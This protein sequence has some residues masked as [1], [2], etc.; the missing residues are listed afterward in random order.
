MTKRTKMLRKQ[1]SKKV[2]EAREASW[3]PESIDTENRT[4]DVVW[5]TGADVARTDFWTGNR[6]IE[7]LKVDEDAIDL[8]RLTSGAALLD[9][10][11]RRSVRNQIGVV[12]SARI[13]D[14]EG[15]ATVRFSERADDIFQDVADG[16]IRK[17]S[18]GY[19]QDERQIT[20]N[21]DGPDLHEI[22]RWTPYELSFVTVPADDGAQVR[23]LEGNEDMDNEQTRDAAAPNDTGAASSEPNV[24]HIAD[25]ATAQK[26]TTAE[27]ER[28]MYINETCDRLGLDADFKRGLIDAGTSRSD[29]AE[30]IIEAKA[31]DP[32]NDVEVDSRIE[33]D[34]GSRRAELKEL[35]GR[36]LMI[37]ENIQG[38]PQDIDEKAKAF[39]FRHFLE[40]ARQVAAVDGIHIP[41]GAG[42]RE[43]AQRAITSV[44]LADT[45]ALVSTRS[46]MQGYQAE[47]RT[48]VDIFR[49]TT[50]NNFQPNQ[51]IKLSDAPKLAVVAEGG[52]IT[53]GTLSDRKEVFSVLKYAKILPFT[54]EMMV[55]DDLSALSRIPFMLGVAAGVTESDVVWGILETNANLSDATPIF[56]AGEDNLVTATPL[57]AAAIE[58]AREYFRTVAAENGTNMGLNPSFL[59]VG[60]DLETT[61]EKLLRAPSD[62][63]TGTLANTLSER[64]RSSIIL[65]VETRIPA[66]DWFLFT[67]SNRVDTLEYGWL[68]GTNG[69]QLET[70]EVFTN[71][72]RKYRAVDIFGAGVLDRRGMYKGV[73]T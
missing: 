2:E 58:A 45:I 18:V 46:L 17:V 1:Q 70:D 20:E 5:T 43:I 30:R 3:R 31:N 33:P 40:V 49:Q 61:A 24:I 48:F 13:E 69:V 54:F 6:Y 23:A 28:V 19:V 67:D 27:R 47:P 32:S 66:G 14:G 8:G 72:D 42:P 34:D 52:T 62:Y 50:I 53:E 59:V 64:L 39:S 51:R 29:A 57:T 12:E 21:E 41:E 15:V 4:A 10:H 55:N 36:G 37:R 71:L 60:P 63:Q 16:I 65:I 26:A 9:S 22:T 35:V 7:R 68:A 38:A 73:I 25:P 56:D 44:T 11:D